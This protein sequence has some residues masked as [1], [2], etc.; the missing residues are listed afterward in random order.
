[1]STYLVAIGLS[2][3]FSL[4][5]SGFEPTGSNIQLTVRHF[6]ALSLSLSPFYLFVKIDTLINVKQIA[7]GNKE[8]F[9]LENGNLCFIETLHKQ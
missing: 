6:V 4:L 7:F 3:L 8:D 2:K 5:K 1:M 9:T